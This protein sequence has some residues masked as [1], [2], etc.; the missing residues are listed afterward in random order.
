MGVC[1]PPKR[2]DIIFNI[3]IG[4]AMS[5]LEPSLIYF[6]VFFF[7]LLLISFCSIIIFLLGEV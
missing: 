3:V 6:I 5:M 7:L 1:R 2:V 4:I